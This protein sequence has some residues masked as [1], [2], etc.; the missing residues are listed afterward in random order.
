MAK[1]GQ[2]GTC[3]YCGAEGPYSEEHYLPECLGK[4]RHYEVLDD[5]ICK[6]CNNS[7]S[8]LDEVLCRTGVTGAI[9]KILEVSDRRGGSPW[10]S[11]RKSFHYA[12]PAEMYDRDGVRYE[13]DGRAGPSIRDSCQLMI[14]KKDGEVTRV[15]IPD[16]ARQDKDRLK[17]FLKDELEGL[18]PD[19]IE[20]IE[21]R[22]YE[23]E[24]NLILAAVAELQLFRYERA[25]LTEV[26]GGQLVDV[27]LKLPI[28]SEY[29][30]A[31]A[32]VGFHYFLKFFPGYRGSEPQFEA[33]REFIKTGENI[34]TDVDIGRFVKINYSLI[35]IS[36]IHRKPPDW[37]G[38]IIGAGVSSG[39]YRAWIRF[40]VISRSKFATPT[41]DIFLGE[42]PFPLHLLKRSSVAHRF[43][44][45]DRG[46]QGKYDG[47]VTKARNLD[48]WLPIRS[49]WRPE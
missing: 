1:K 35:S 17:R 14:H 34:K 27:T 8:N 12:D 30:R 3:I 32:K 13:P 43:E 6:R 25:E 5:R 19:D 41:F 44:Y 37:S 28:T 42:N 2:E 46:K 20:K 47:E 10:D 39:D 4:F 36:D 33:I 49:L 24:W 31:V 9:R 18:N 40:G 48:L 29:M 7:F 38:H 23:G 45:F 21:G 15:L 22:F 26:P 11:F 16:W